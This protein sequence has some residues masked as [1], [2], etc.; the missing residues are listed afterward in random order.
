MQI[1][2]RRKGEGEAIWAWNARSSKADTAERMG[3][4]RVGETNLGAQEEKEGEKPGKGCKNRNMEP[5]TAG[6]RIF[7]QHYKK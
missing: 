6:K 5:T 4:R 7:V 1:D 3:G 2:S